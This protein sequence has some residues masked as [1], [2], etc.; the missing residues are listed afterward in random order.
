MIEVTGITKRYGD[1]LAVDD[2]S[3]EVKPGQIT[4]FL[5]PMDRASRP[6]CA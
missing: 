2:L 1:T 6:P 5:D 3:F 4:G